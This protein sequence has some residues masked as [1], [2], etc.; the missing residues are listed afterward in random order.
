VAGA[1]RTLAEYTT[2]GNIYQPC[3]ALAPDAALTEA[4]IFNYIALTSMTARAEAR[5]TGLAAK[6]LV[7]GATTAERAASALGNQPLRERFLDGRAAVHRGIAFAN[8]LGASWASGLRTRCGPP[9][10]SSTSA[11]PCTTPAI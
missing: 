5:C 8:S 7:A 10:T 9:I 1:G 11:P 6:G 2:Y 3:A 4:S